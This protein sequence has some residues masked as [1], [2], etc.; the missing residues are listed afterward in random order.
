MSCHLLDAG[1]NGWCIFKRFFFCT[2]SIWYYIFPGFIFIIFYFFECVSSS[3]YLI[4][5]AA[6][7]FTLP[8]SPPPLLLRF[9]SLIISFFLFFLHTHTFSFHLISSMNKSRHADD[10]RIAQKLH[11]VYLFN[12]FFCCYVRPEKSIYFVLNDDGVYAICPKIESI[13]FF[14]NDKTTDTQF[15]GLPTR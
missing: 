1:P 4:L 14:Y 5:F 11:F 6:D 8:P 10:R 9:C 7:I 13:F 2:N 3:P 15:V 12:F